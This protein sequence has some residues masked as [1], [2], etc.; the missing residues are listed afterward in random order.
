MRARLHA[1]RIPLL[2]DVV[3]LAGAGLIP[4]GTRRN[5]EAVAATVEWDPGLSETLRF[6]IGDAQTSGGLL[7]GTPDPDA[8]LRALAAAGVSGAARIGEVVGE[9][10]TGAIEVTA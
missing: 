2:P 6:V 8:Y 10:P 3:A 1:G 4:G 7:V 5:L 9:D